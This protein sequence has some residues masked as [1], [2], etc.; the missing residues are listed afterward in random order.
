MKEIRQIYDS[1]GGVVS[2]IVFRGAAESWHT[3]SVQDVEPI[4]N[5]NKALI[6]EGHNGFTPSREM[7]HVAKIPSV[8]YADW[9]KEFC[10]KENLRHFGNRDI[11]RWQAFLKAKLNDSDNKYLRC[12]EGKV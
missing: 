4:L 1:F 10:R 3:R 5:F 2:E 6:N 9:Q 12:V 8:I 11:K 7:R